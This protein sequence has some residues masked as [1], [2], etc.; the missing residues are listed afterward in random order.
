[1]TRCPFSLARLVKVTETSQV[2]YQAEKG[3][4]RSFPDPGGDG[5]QAGRAPSRSDGRRNY[6]ILSPLDFLAEFT[7]HFP[8]KGAHL[9]RYYGWYSNKSRGMRKEAAVEATGES[10]PAADASSGAS[11]RCSQSWAMLIKRVYEVDPLS[12]PEC[13]GQMAV[14][15]FIEPPQA[16]VIEKILSGHQSGAMVGGLWRS[17]A[18]RAPPA[19]SIDPSGGGSGSTNGSDNKPVELT[20]VDM[21]T[22]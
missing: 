16:D 8:A 22:Y 1:M 3:S 5:I 9:I 21:A 2:V 15:A 4:C 7:Q 13:G 14:V 10:S 6:Q 20:Y 11:N 17:V 12:C 18:A 19:D